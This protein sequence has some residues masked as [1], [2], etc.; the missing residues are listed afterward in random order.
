M[1]EGSTT[2]RS[3]GSSSASREPPAAHTLVLLDANALV[4]WAHRTD[5][6]REEID[7]LAG[8]AEVAVPAPVIRELD[9][10]IE[11]GVPDAVLAR[12]LAG[13]FAQIDHPGRGDDA[14]VDLAVAR[15]AI[16]VTADREL[17]ERLFAAGRDV[18][19][20]RDRTR[21][22]RHAGRARI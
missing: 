14:I 2:G 15:R 17:A 11:R 19:M 4:Q 20:S 21:L 3:S 10:L 12:T 13:R 7:R 1:G 6:L 8:P 9:R 22:V 5:S 16:V 18:L